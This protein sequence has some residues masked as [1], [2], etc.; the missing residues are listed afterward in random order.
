MGGPHPKTLSAGV[1]ERSVE[2]CR[3]STGGVRDTLAQRHLL[4]T[5]IA[6][7]SPA[8]RGL[9]GR[10]APVRGASGARVRGLPRVQRP[11]LPRV[12]ALRG[13]VL[14]A[15]ESASAFFFAGRSLAIFSPSE[16]YFA[17]KR[18]SIKA[19][20][21]FLLALTRRRCSRNLTIFI[22]R[23]GGYVIKI[24]SFETFRPRM[25]DAKRG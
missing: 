3:E 8:R 11:A 23:V 19:R 5:T 22:L 4:K 10:R 12:P 16:T 14:S 18:N 2:V 15:T 20:L 24:H 9:H 13:P 17:D 21:K 1:S 25:H 7:T 6:T